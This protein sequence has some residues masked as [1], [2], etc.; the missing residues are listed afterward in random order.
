MPYSH[1]GQVG[2]GHYTT[3]GLQW[4]FLA[5]LQFGLTSYSRTHGLFVWLGLLDECQ[6]PSGIPRQPS[7]T[8]LA[9][10]GSNHS[11]DAT[12]NDNHHLLP[13]MLLGPPRKHVLQLQS[14]I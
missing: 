3:S 10:G 7:P 14:P 2:C 1:S 4:H 12:Y 5:L 9:T 11:K 6:L 13:E 8:G